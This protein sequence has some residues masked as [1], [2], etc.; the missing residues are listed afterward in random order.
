M[1]LASMLAES[2]LLIST[3][4]HQRGGN[5][6]QAHL[7]HGRL[8]GRKGDAI[9]SDIGQAGLGAAH[10]NVH[11]FA[12]DAIERNRRQAADGIGDIGVGQAGDDFGGKTCTMLS[13]MRVSLIAS[14]SPCTRSAETIMF[15]LAVA[16]A[17]LT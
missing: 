15:S 7:A 9:H 1:P 2:V 17:S 13:A 11:A 8:R 14:A 12:L 3:A 16:T 10:L 6:V 5:H 4:I